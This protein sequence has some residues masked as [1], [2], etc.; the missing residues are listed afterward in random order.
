MLEGTLVFAAG[1]FGDYNIFLYDFSAG[2]LMQ[3]TSGIAWNDYPRFSPDAKKIAFG[4][5]RSGKQEIWLMNVDGSG[6]ES[7][8]AGL[9]WADFPTW[10]PDG[11]EIAFVSN[12]YF[13][14]DLFALNLE[15]LKIRL[16]GNADYYLKFD[17]DFDRSTSE[18][19]RILDELRSLQ[20]GDLDFEGLMH[21][22]VLTREALNVA[23]PVAFYMEQKD[24]VHKSDKATQGSIDPETAK[25][26][27][28]IL[29][30]I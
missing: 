8:T 16:V 11:K 30:G 29:R 28:H 24:R 1:N 15:T 12:E 20:A 7:L 23:K 6:A 27:V 2:K 17:D 25:V 13:Q 26:L 5:T 9:K 22:E 19:K 14:E 3:L 21:L 10:S 18:L 4:S